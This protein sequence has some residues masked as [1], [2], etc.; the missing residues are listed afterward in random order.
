MAAVAGALSH[1]DYKL[2]VEAHFIF[3]TAPETAAVLRQG[4]K[5]MLSINEISTV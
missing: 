5:V 1:M 3:C 2:L 4:I